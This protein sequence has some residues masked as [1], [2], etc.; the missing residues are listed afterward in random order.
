MSKRFV[1]NTWRL[2]LALCLV[3]L[4]ITGCAKETSSESEPRARDE[5]PPEVV[6]TPQQ[7]ART[8]MEAGDYESAAAIAQKLLITDPSDETLLLA[9]T[10]ESKRDQSRRVVELLAEIDL[11]QSA[12]A[13]EVAPILIQHS[14]RTGN[15]AITEATL[16]TMSERQSRQPPVAASALAT[17]EPPRPATGSQRTGGC[18]VPY[19]PSPP[20]TFGFADSPQRTVS[21]SH[22]QRATESDLVLAATAPREVVHR[23]GTLTPRRWRHL[24]PTRP[25]RPR[26]KP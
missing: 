10:I 19:G 8:K 7:T 25:L 2:Q 9:A 20:R 15:V 24:I 18:A 26:R 16:R 12:F 1:A 23:C 14:M 3:V 22:R 5:Q 17:T 4:S 21:G 13:S 11:T 6:E